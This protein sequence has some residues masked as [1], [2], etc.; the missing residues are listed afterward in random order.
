MKNFLL[1]IVTMLLLSVGLW[2]FVLRPGISPIVTVTGA[3]ANSEVAAMM[4]T[5]SQV[6]A[7]QMRYESAQYHFT[8]LYPSELGKV[9]DTPESGGGHTVVFDDGKDGGQSF[10]IYV[11]PYTGET[12]SKERFLADEPSGVSKEQKVVLIDGVRA[13]LFTGYNDSIGDT[14]EVWFIRGGFLYEVVTY[15]EL[16]IW[17]AEIMKSWKFI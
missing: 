1:G 14:R 3:A 12:I 4:G 16:D 9:N 8:V 13:T 15:K 10:Q 17:L 11:T 2:W 7:S 6:T 5:T